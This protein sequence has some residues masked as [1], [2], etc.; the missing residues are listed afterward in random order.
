MRWFLATMILAAGF[1]PPVRY[2]HAHAHD[3]EHAH[4]GRSE[5]H[6]HDPPGGDHD[7]HLPTLEDVSFHWHDG[8]L[9]IPPSV[10]TPASD[11][12]PPQVTQ[13]DSRIDAVPPTSPGR[14]GIGLPSPFW[15]PASIPIPWW[16]PPGLPSH[17]HPAFADPPRTPPPTLVGSVLIRC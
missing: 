1:G 16:P 15:L 10:P 6:D 14:I 8:W 13:V 17:R 11:G 5:H 2:G 3:G 7:H 12:A 9:P 4:H